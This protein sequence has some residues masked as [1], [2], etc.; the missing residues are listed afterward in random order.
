M[1]K[2][3]IIL[4]ASLFVF[5]CWEKGDKGDKG[6][7]GIDYYHDEDFDGKTTIK[8]ELNG[9]A[10]N[11]PCL[12]PGAIDVYPLDEDWYQTGNPVHGYI[13][14]N[15]GSFAADGY[16]SG[17]YAYYSASDLTCFN[18]ISAGYDNGIRFFSMTDLTSS[19]RNLNPGTTI[20]FYV[21]DTYFKDI[22]HECYHDPTCATGTAQS[23]II[24]YFDMPATGVNFEM[25]TLQGDTTADAVL[26]IIDSMIANGRSASEQNAYMLDIADGVLNNNLTLK[27]DI[28]N[29]I[30]ALPIKTIKTNLENIY[31]DLG[32]GPLCP[33][34]WNLPHLPEYYAD[35]LTRTPTI[36]E[37]INLDAGSICSFDT[38]GYNSFAYPTIFNSLEDAVYFASELNGDISIWTVGTCNQ[39]VDYPCPLSEIVT[40]EEL[41]EILLEPVLNYNGYLGNH[42]LINGTQYFTV[43]NFDDLM[44]QPSHAC[45]GEMVPF[46]RILAAVDNNWGAA[47]GWNNTTSWFRR[48]PKI[49]I[50]D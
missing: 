18:E 36:L 16:A 5:G 1:K 24:A 32:L 14:D 30:N 28:Q 38:T 25:M 4:L 39:G 21:A 34:I 15:D 27:T 41:N 46:G 3:L 29:Q 26:A 2:L 12:K 11:G 42:G 8:Y 48:M 47:V 9:K 44:H 13:Y 22:N 49:F 20:K 7:D 10:E 37:S 31:T 45:D 35:I 6:E 23:N 40:V 17:N 19:E 43:Q 50:T 33:P